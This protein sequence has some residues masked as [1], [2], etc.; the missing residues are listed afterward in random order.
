VGEVAK[1]LGLY[2]QYTENMTV[3]E[4]IRLGFDLS[5]LEEL[6]SWKE[7]KDKSYYIVPTAQDWENIPAGLRRFYE[8]PEKYPL[9]TPSGKLEFYPRGWRGF[10]G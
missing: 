6:V 4:K 9:E 5:G 3:E 8:D 10:P 1:K 2:D 7:F